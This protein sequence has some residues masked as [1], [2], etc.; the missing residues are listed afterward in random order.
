MNIVKKIIKGKL[1]KIN[2][3]KYY[4][5]DKVCCIVKNY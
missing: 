4:K 2:K 1:I 3:K 5:N